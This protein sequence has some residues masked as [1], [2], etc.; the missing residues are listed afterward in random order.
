MLLKILIAL[1]AVVV[2]FIIVV[3]L[4]PAS[5]R[6]VRSASVSAPPGAVF[7]RVNDFHQWE[8]WSPWLKLD[9]AC[10]TTYEGPSAGVG[11]AFAWSGNSKVGEGRMTVIESRPNELIRIRLD[12]EKP[13]KSTSTAEFT[14]KP[15]GDRT[16]RHVE[17]VRGEELFL[18]SLLPLH[19]HGQ[20]G[21]RGFR[22]RAG[23]T[24]NSHGSGTGA[25][26]SRG[27]SAGTGGPSRREIH[28]LQGGTTR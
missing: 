14:F 11:A 20:D 2:V 9:P 8:A 27:D 7:A 25:V 26:V 15:E 13:F 10:K 17:H 23:A 22:K 21:R 16:E 28:N 4:Q 18:Q 12:F 6:V 1:A 24:E 19:G 5:F 3:A